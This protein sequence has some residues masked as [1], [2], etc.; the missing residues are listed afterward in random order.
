MSATVQPASKPSSRRALLAGALGGLAAWAASTAARVSPAEAAAGDPI[1]MG[2]LNKAS[3]TSTTVQSKTSKAVLQAMQL[4]GG[5]ALRG[6]AA[7]GRGVM[8]VAGSDGTGVW[9]YSPNHYGVYAKSDSGIAVEAVAGPAGAAI[10]AVNEAG[11]AISAYT[12]GGTAI[13][14]TNESE[15]GGSALVGRITGVPGFFSG[16]AVWGST[17]GTAYAWAGRFDGHVQISKDLHLLPTQVDSNDDQVSGANLF[18]RQNMSGKVELCVVFP[19][20]PVQVIAT[21]P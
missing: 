4:G 5:T 21:E 13:Q 7:S 14:A 3:D 2:R 8:G 11:L 9:A 19:T 17:P 12:N 6:E 18:A 1:R 16:A 10:G 20:G 15:G